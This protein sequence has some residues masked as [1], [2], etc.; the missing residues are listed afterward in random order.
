MLR[1]TNSIALRESELS[2][3][4]LR[5]SGPGGQN[6]NKVSTAVQLRFDAAHSPSLP[7]HVRRRLMRLAG[8]RLTRAGTLVISASEHRSRELNRRAA[9]ERL[10]A[11]IRRAAQPP[12]PRRKT[13][14]TLASVQKRLAHKRRR[15]DLKR[16][17]RLGPRSW[18]G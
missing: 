15:S 4:F 18:D 2:E 3:S 5:A 17:R 8:G 14:P 9:R 1:V 10:I 6:V 13:R 11:L 16:R 12:V 7:E